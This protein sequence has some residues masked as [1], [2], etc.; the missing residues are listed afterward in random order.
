MNAAL[1]ALI[2]RRE[3][4][5]RM[6]PKTSELDRAL[7]SIRRHDAALKPRRKH[8]R[9]C[10]RPSHPVRIA[11]EALKRFTT[12]DV[13][14]VT[15]QAIAN[16]QANINGLRWA[17]RLRAV[18]ESVA[19]PAVYERVQGGTLAGRMRNPG[20][21]KIEAMPIGQRFGLADLPG[22][23]SQRAEAVLRTRKMGMVRRVSVRKTF[24]VWEVIP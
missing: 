8:V 6:M 21:V 1:K 22:T 16:V 12:R 2:P 7:A 10:P 23:K 3:T 19:L 14:L 9:Y 20:M 17:G 11:A 13:A 24:T 18:E 15:G 4:V 5:A